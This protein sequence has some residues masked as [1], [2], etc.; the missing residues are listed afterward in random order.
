[1]TPLETALDYLGR[2]WSPIPI[3][4]KSKRPIGDEWQN[5]RITRANAGQ[6]FNGDTQ[7]IG[8]L[9]GEASGART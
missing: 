2:G 8:V 7:N 4:H 9:L 1:M 5:R 3:P 6:W